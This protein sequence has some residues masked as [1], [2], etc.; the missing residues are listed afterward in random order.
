MK[1]KGLY[2]KSRKDTRY[3]PWTVK[4]PSPPS[5]AVVPIQH[6][7]EHASE[8]MVKIGDRV[9]VGSKIAKPTHALS[10]FIVSPIAGK[11]T[12]VGV[13]PHPVL[14]S[15]KAFEITADDSDEKVLGFGKERK[16]WA[17]LNDAERIRIIS[18]SGIVL[19]D[20]YLTPFDY[21]IK[22]EMLKKPQ[23][24]IIDGCEPEPYGS[25]GY[26]L[27]MSHPVELLR[28]IEIVRSLL[29]IQKVVVVIDDHLA[30]AAELLKSKI[31][32]LKWSH[33]EVLIVPTLY[34]S[35]PVR[36]SGVDPD[37]A[38]VLDTAALFAVYE[39]VV[40][41]KPPIERVI[42][43]NGECLFEP[44]NL[45]V[46][47]GTLFSDAMKYCKGLLR[48]PGKLLHGGP[49]SGRAQASAQVPVLFSTSSILAL[50]K[51]MIQMAEAEAC[52]R[53]GDCLNVCPE[54]ISPAMIMFAVEAGL[55]QEAR[56]LGAEDCTACGNCTYVC[57][58]KISVLDKI[59]PA[60]S[61]MRQEDAD[62]PF[63]EDEFKE[64]LLE[65]TAQQPELIN[66]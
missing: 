63:F 24:L 7:P 32:F 18:E 38:V 62:L 16:D 6:H 13:Y 31:Y 66:R 42:T 23:R 25:A 40:M 59:Q 36:R 39:A 35:Q 11:V 64:K 26:S 50:P 34:P 27:I 46:R 43:I 33:I 3:I 22:S 61:G 2:F 49:L 28:G 5:K 53:C 21:F 51:E 29:G 52:I 12:G 41:Q 17:K 48:E 30:E 20:P 19:P 44:A 47:Q 8:P 45:W 60:L 14:G 37:T 4:R 65:E 58:S 57:P 9:L 55:L 56:N 54:N 1:Y 15:A 10:S